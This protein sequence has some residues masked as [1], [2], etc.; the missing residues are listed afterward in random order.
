MQEILS[1]MEDAFEEEERD[2]NF[3]RDAAFLV[4]HRRVAEQVCKLYDGPRKCQC[5]HRH[6]CAQPPSV[7]CS[8]LLEP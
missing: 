3:S 7:R 8:N 5:N 1:S 4:R 6:Y 2:S